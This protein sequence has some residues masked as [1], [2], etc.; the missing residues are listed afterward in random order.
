MCTK[1]SKYYLYACVNFVSSE[2]SETQVNLITRSKFMEGGFEKTLL[3]CLDS[4][5]NSQQNQS[6]DS[7]YYY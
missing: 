6:F 3:I 4:C 2:V 7:D 5:E 1:C